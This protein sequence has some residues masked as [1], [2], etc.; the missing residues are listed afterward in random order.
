MNK[1]FRVIKI[2]DDTSLIVNAGLEDGIESGDSMEIC[3]RGADII[4]PVTKEKLGKLEI[5]KAKLNVSEVYDK[6]CICET[7]Y[8]SNYFATLI[9]NPLF[10][11]TQKKLDVEPTEISG[12]GDKT[13]RIGDVAKHI[14]KEKQVEKTETKSEED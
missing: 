14:K 10:S 1:E 6:M 4:D 7:V 8:V 3:S 11:S 9:S 12:E 13:I 2:I 5:T